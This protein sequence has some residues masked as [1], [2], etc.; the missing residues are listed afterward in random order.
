MPSN[1][2]AAYNAYVTAVE[3]AFA[4]TLT[5][6]DGDT[7]ELDAEHLVILGTSGWEQNLADMEGDQDEVFVIDNVLHVGYT[8]NTAKEARDRAFT[9]LAT[10]ENLIGASPTLTGANTVCDFKPQAYTPFVDTEGQTVQIGFGVEVRA[11]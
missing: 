2:P 5:V 10:V 1:I 6:T 7:A 9:L 3:A 11:V 4:G 8:G